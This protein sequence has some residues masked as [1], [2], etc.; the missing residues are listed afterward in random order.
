MTN[1]EI[2]ENYDSIQKLRDTSL[3]PWEDVL[4]TSDFLA[5][6]DRE[7]QTYNKANT[8]LQLKYARFGLV[9]M[10]AREEKKTTESD[11]DNQSS[12]NIDTEL[13][14]LTGDGL[15]I[16]EMASRETEANELL[17]RETSKIQVP[18][19]DIKVIKKLYEDSKARREKEDAAGA[20]K[21]KENQ[22]RKEEPYFTTDDVRAY[23][24][25]KLT[26]KPEKKSA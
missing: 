25:L 6:F 15:K 3:L 16:E 26:A 13:L 9:N 22:G 24:V 4:E 2:V 12:E 7:F 8:N 5:G 20:K 19:V 10:K 18:D 1:R 21:D 23:I 17:D 14:L 11:E